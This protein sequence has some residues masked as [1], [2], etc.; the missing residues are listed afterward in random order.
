[1][2]RLAR[3]REPD[4]PTQEEMEQE[5]QEYFLPVLEAEQ[6]NTAKQGKL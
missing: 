6:A 3:K 2:G 4:L 5:Y 1:M